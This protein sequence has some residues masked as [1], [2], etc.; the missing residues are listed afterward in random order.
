MESSR[1][2]L[3]H[4]LYWIKLIMERLHIRYRLKELLMCSMRAFS[5]SWNRHKSIS[6][7]YYILFPSTAC[8]YLKY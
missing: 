8:L 5:L 4:F 2:I 3:N 1:K 6:A 7:A